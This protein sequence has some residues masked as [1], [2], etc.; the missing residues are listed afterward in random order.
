MSIIRDAFADAVFK[1]K[2]FIIT[3]CRTKVENQ[4]LGWL[5][6]FDQD[7]GEKQVEEEEVQGLLDEEKKQLEQIQV[8]E[9]YVIRV[10]PVSWLFFSFRRK[11]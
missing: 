9:T 5:Q 2:L 4:L 7:I 6:K 1:N 3:T 10:L 11:S 8:K